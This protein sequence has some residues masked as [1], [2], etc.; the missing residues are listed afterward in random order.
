[1]TEEMLDLV[2]LITKLDELRQEF[3]LT[4]EGLHKVTGVMEDFAWETSKHF[5]LRDSERKV[6]E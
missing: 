4:F 1:M 3:T 5:P 6:I 2:E